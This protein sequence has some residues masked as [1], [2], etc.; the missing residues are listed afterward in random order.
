LHEDEKCVAQINGPEAKKQRLLP[1]E[2]FPQMLE[3]SH[4]SL[5]SIHESQAPFAELIFLDGL[6][7]VFLGRPHNN[8]GSS[9]GLAT[10]MFTP[11]S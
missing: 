9:S 1:T 8:I 4:S 3:R 2:R 5:E 6:F 11:L 10:D 7:A